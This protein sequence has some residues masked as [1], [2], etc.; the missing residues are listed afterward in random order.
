MIISKV[1]LLVL[2]TQQQV[3]MFDIL[4][5]KQLNECIIK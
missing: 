2:N 3:E 4:E 1:Q 5:F